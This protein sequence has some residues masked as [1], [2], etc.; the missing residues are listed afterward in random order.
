MLCRLLEG[1]VAASLLD[2]SQTAA[3]GQQSK[4]LTPGTSEGK[5]KITSSLVPRSFASCLLEVFLIF[6]LYKKCIKLF[7]FADI[8]H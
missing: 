4:H 3:S 1:E 6:Q 8:V 5:Q 7:C 2:L